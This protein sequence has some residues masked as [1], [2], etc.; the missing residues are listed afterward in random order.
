LIIHQKPFFRKKM[1]I[2]PQTDIMGNRAV[3]FNRKMPDTTIAAQLVKLIRELGPRA[4]RV[5]FV[6][7]GNTEL[8]TG[9]AELARMFGLDVVVV[10]DK[11]T[12]EE[13]VGL[14][15]THS[16]L[17]DLEAWESGT[18][19]VMLWPIFEN[20]TGDAEALQFPHEASLVFFAPSGENGSREM[21]RDLSGTEGCKYPV[22]IFSSHVLEVGTGSGMLGL[23]LVLQTHMRGYVDEPECPDPTQTDLPRGDALFMLTKIGTSILYGTRGPAE[24]EF[25]TETIA[26]ELRKLGMNATNSDL[27][28]KI[29]LATVVAK[30]GA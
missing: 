14:E 5:V 13:N 25:L 26:P 21:I 10:G 28:R 27:M 2:A 16:T 11:P 19:L 20:P 30:L 7:S 12:S 9:M 6:V 4:K 1:A 23:T 8:E 15:T 29:G 17:G 22:S 18:I 24:T 3:F